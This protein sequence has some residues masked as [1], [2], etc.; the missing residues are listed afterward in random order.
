VTGRFAADFANRTV[1]WN[2]RAPQPHRDL[3]P[4][5][6][7]LFVELWWP[8][9]VRRGS[10]ARKL[11]TSV[12]LVEG[13]A[14][15]DPAKFEALYDLNFERVYASL[16]SRVRDRAAAEDLTSEVFH[17]ALA[18][19]PRYEWRGVPFA[20]W[21]LRIAANAVADEFK[22]AAREF[23][24]PDDPPEAPADRDLQASELRAIEHRAQLFHLVGQLPEVQK[25]VGVRAICG[26]TEYKGDCE[27]TGEDSRG[28]QATAIAARCRI[29]RAQMEVAMA[30]RSLALQA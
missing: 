15:S 27:A 6:Q 23:P 2:R 18:N 8:P 7:L 20:A 29:C 25:R 4:A 12:L 22:R 19:L 14:Q 26:T 10:L 1:R 16:P 17:K 21:L 9:D 3:F 5:R 11:R 28:H 30:K 24:S 13:A